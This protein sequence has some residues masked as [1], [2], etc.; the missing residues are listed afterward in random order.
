MNSSSS[1][2]IPRDTNTI[3]NIH[4]SNV[5]SHFNN[6][7]FQLFMVHFT[8][9]PNFKNLKYFSTFTISN[10][11]SCTSRLIVNYNI[12]DVE[13]NY[14]NK[15]IFNLF[16]SYFTSFQ[17]YLEIISKLKTFVVIIIF[18][19]LMM[20]NRIIIHRSFKTQF[21]VVIMKKFSTLFTN[22]DF[23]K[24]LEKNWMKI[25][26]RFDWQNR[27]FKKIKVYSLNIKNRDL[28]DQIFD[29]LHEQN[30]MS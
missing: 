7:N 27:I 30:R 21:F 24:L 5:I 29:K 2:V 19:D 18:F 4:S 12:N 16:F 8:S 17:V 9:I 28:I 20:S 10:H 1:N 26:L 22:A 15:I 23:V 3:I 13:N 14:A 11:L 6:I 25:S